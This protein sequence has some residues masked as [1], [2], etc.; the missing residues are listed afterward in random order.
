M[1]LPARPPCTARRLRQPGIRAA[2][3]HRKRTHLRM[4]RVHAG[5]RGQMLYAGTRHMNTL[6]YDQ[7]AAAIQAVGEVLRSG[8]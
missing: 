2:C 6:G 5:L 4:W 3:R 8:R 7:H 1:I